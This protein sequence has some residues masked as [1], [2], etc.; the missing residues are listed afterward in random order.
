MAGRPYIPTAPVLCYF[1]FETTGLDPD[2]G[3]EPIEIA[4]ICVDT[5]QPGLPE[6][7]RFPARLMRVEYP[8][9]A[10]PRALQVNNKTIEEVMAGEDPQLVFT[11]FVLWCLQM[12]GQ[13][14]RIMLGGHN[15]K[16]D[17]KFLRWAFNKYLP[18]KDF[19]MIF[20][21][22]EV[23][24][25]SVFFFKHVLTKR[26]VK[27]SSLVTATSM[28][29]LPH[30]AHEAMGDVE[31]GIQVLRLMAEE[32]MKADV[33]RRLAAVLPHILYGESADVDFS[34]VDELI[35]KAFPEIDISNESTF[36]RVVR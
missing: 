15:V 13:R 20:D 24:S 2:E 31:A 8:E 3:A 19:E 30:S 7:G 32:E 36:P 35:K 29:N 22:H 6:I 17:I 14:G 11:Q 9:N 16:F 10:H 28:Y 18:G 5:S 23:C 34:A 25:H 4:A 12:S 21:H 33:H 1:D 26:S 27:K